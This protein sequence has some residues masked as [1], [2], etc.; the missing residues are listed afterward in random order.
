MS[1]E[2]LPYILILYYSRHG[3]TAEMAKHI[4]RGVEEIDNSTTRFVYISNI[5]VDYYNVLQ[6]TET[7]RLRWKIENEGF[8]IQKN[9][10]Y[11]LHH[12]YSRVSMTATKNYYQCMQIAHMIN[13]LFE[14]GSLLKPLLRGKM[15][16]THLWMVMLGELRHTL[17]EVEVL[18]TLLK[19]RI[20]I[21]YE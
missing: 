3:A 2:S 21:R 11:G 14:L 20:Q 9:H 4:A 16:I 17:L 13:Q 8:D 1:V 19:N 15:T 5:K 18:E 12:K 6:M 7:G 10:G